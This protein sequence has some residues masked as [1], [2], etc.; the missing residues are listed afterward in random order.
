MGRIVSFEL[1]RTYADIP[2]IAFGLF[3]RNIHPAAAAEQAAPDPAAGTPK[4]APA[5][6]RPPKGRRK[7]KQ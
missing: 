6:R 3:G 1:S 7:R 2:Q 4:K 5:R